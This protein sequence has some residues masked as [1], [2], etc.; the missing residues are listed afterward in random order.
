MARWRAEGDA[1]LQPRSRRPHSSPTATPPA[2]VELIVNLRANL[3]G[4]GLDHGPATI[5]W[6][7][8]HEHQRTVS[9][10][11]VARILTREGLVTPAPKKRPRSSYLRFE[12]ALPNE[13]W[14]SDF[15]HWNLPGDR[16]VEIITWLDDCTRYALTVTAHTRVTGAIV[17]ATFRATISIHG[18]PASTLTDNGM[19]FTVRL[20]GRGRRGGRNAFEHELQRLGIQ[21]KN[22]SPS[23]PQTQGKVERFQQTMKKWLTAQPTPASIPEL[24][25]QLDDFVHEYNHRRPHRSLPHH[26]TPAARYQSM[27]KAAPGGLRDNPHDRVRHDK[28]SKNGVVTLRYAGKLRH[29]PVGRANTGTRVLLLIQD[30]HVTVLNTATGEVI[31]ELTIDPNRD[32][33]ALKTNNA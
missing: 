4:R 8:E 28:I 19:V 6:H 3:Q 17:L 27:P 24:Q 21:Q 33:Q 11:T 1:A 30:D 22:G 16:D 13:C 12:A 26:A 10:A 31:R 14:Q 2:T 15:T 25:T 29:I 18:T 9:R 5:V 20:A 7:L 32:Y 23:H